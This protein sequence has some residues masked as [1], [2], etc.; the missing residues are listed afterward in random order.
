MGLMLT[1]YR[2]MGAVHRRRLSDSS[3]DRD[4]LVAVLIAHG[5][6]VAV[7][8]TPSTIMRLGGTWK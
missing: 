2:I 4:R 7:D 3:E 1:R 8:W 6:V 5:A